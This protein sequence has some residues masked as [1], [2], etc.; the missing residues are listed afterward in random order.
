VCRSQIPGR[1]QFNGTRN[2]RVFDTVACKQ[3]GVQEEG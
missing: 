2:G 3:A 1:Q